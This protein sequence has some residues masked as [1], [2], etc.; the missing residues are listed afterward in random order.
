MSARGSESGWMVRPNSAYPS[1][2]L[3][4]PSVITVAVRTQPN[5][6]RGWR[7]ITRPHVAPSVRRP[8]RPALARTVVDHSGLSPARGLVPGLSRLANAST[9][10]ATARTPITAAISAPD[11]G[12]QARLAGGTIRGAIGRPTRPRC[13]ARGALVMG[14]LLEA[15]AVITYHIDVEP[16][17]ADGLER[18]SITERRPGGP[19]AQVVECQ[20]P[21]EAGAIGPYHVNGPVVAGRIGRSFDSIPA[22]VERDP[23]SIRGPAWITAEATAV[24]QAPDGAGL[25]VHYINVVPTVACRLVSDPP[26]VR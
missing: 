10:L 7:Q 16:T 22:A 20:Q 8:N 24:R 25:Y 1:A 2:T 14:Q 23:A 15:R 11:L 18:D 4:M 19:R 21:V 3:P 13:R 12:D 26:A 6:L 17:G 9:P 5:R